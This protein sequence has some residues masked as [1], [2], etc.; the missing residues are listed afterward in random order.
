MKMKPPKFFKMSAD[1]GNDD[2]MYS[3][4]NCLRDGQGIEQNLSEALKYYKMSADL[5]NEEAQEQ[6]KKLTNQ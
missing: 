6:Y 1:A 5:G 3:Y 2:G 4:A